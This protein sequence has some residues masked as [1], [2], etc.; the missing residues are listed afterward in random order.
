MICRCAR[1]HLAGGCKRAALGLTGFAAW[2]RSA[3]R[4]W[5]GD[6]ARPMSDV[7]KIRWNR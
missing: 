5:W 3:V 1:C 2:V 4:R 7:I 6:R